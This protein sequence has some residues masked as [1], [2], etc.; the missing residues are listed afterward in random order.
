MAMKNRMCFMTAGLA[1]GA[2]L[3]AFGQAVV[4][5]SDAA[6]TQNAGT[7]IVEV[8]Y[9]LAGDTPV[10]VTLG[11]ETNGVAIP[12]PAAVWGDVTTAANPAPVEP[13]PA[14]KKIFWSAKT[15]WPSN[16]TTEARAV[17]TAWFTNDPPAALVLYAVVDLSGGPSAATY[18]VRYSAAAPDVSAPACKTTELW[19]RRIPAGTFTMGS[20]A[21][22]LGRN[23]S[24]TQETQ[25]T[26]TLSRDFFI[27]VFEVTQ[28]Q[29]WQVTGE[30][31]AFNTNLTYWATRPVEQVSWN[32]IREGATDTSARNAALT[33][34]AADGVGDG[35]FM[36]ALRMKTGLKFDLPSEA[37]REYACRAGT[38]GAWNNGTTITN[39]T[40]DANLSLLAR[41]NVSDSA[42]RNCD[43][44]NKNTAPVGSYLPNA[45]GL[46]D[47]HGNVCEWVLDR[48]VASMSGT[49]VVDPKGP[50]SGDNRMYRDGNC[51]GP[52]SQNR[53]ANRTLT[54]V[55]WFVHQ[56]VGF[57][58]AIQPTE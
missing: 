18:P 42:D 35:S 25:H 43:I 23:M 31:P 26:V 54:A 37:Q 50:A 24:G 39:V 21:D 34:P 17:V 2:V 14:P 28:Q 49:A 33:W 48:F 22:E 53:S 8:S 15:D 41:Y 6:L 29:Y 47:M 58:V 52:A 20:P 10:Y 11:I 13:G 27:G 45:W 30:K 46:Y 19:L 56:R 55:P 5:L 9:Q 57:R 16:L 4:N 40:K 1:A 32:R 38:T 3:Q 12:D 36:H 44:S 51:T 7:R